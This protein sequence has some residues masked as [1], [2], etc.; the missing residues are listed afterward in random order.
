MTPPAPVP[1]L[2]LTPPDAPR[3]RRASTA[4]QQSR[5]RAVLEWLRPIVQKRARE[6]AADRA[7]RLGR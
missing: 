3:R 7:R 6:E 4:W 5:V 2:V 1:P